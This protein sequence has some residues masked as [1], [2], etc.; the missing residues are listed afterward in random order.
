VTIWWILGCRSRSAS[1]RS[2]TRPPSRPLSPSSSRQ[3]R[4][5]AAVSLQQRP[6]RVGRLAGPALAALLYAWKGPAACYGMNAASYLVVTIAMMSF[7]TSELHPR[8]TRA[9]ARWRATGEPRLLLALNR[10]TGGQLLR[11]CFVGMFACELRHLLRLVHQLV[12]HAGSVS[13]GI[14]ESINAGQP[15]SV[16]CPVRVA[17]RNPTRAYL[18]RACV[19][20]GAAALALTALR[21][22][23]SWGLLLLQCPVRVRCRQPIRRQPDG[24]PNST[25]E[26]PDAAVRWRSRPTAR[27]ARDA[28]RCLDRWAGWTVPRGRHG[29]AIGAGGVLLARV[30][31]VVLAL[32]SRRQRRDGLPRIPT[33]IARSPLGPSS[34]IAGSST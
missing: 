3:S 32:S 20:L 9:H 4:S 26:R 8:R 30:P 16:G 6:K 13:L 25:H 15:S 24:P 27:L 31:R 12:L 19:G 21:R 5:R 14:A 17:L 18:R 23:I 10:R 11:E 2:S 22:R 33:Q 29:H 34:A 28:D 1:P 7:R